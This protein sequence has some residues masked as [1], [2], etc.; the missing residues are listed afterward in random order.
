MA[1][2]TP[3]QSSKW[4]SWGFILGWKPHLA[5]RGIL[6][7]QYRGFIFIS[8]ACHHLKIGRKK[9]EKK[10]E[11]SH[12]TRSW[13]YSR[14]GRSSS[15]AWKWVGWLVPA[16]CTKSLPTLCDSMDCSPPGSSVHGILQ[17]STLEWVA[18]PF[19]R[20]SSWPRDWTWASYVSC[21]GRWVFFITR[22]TWVPALVSLICAW[23]LWL[24]LGRTYPE[25]LVS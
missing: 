17:A 23:S 8:H 20:G 5:H 21:I 3:L 7:G 14:S 1:V 13:G 16:L 6:L 18:I 4:E 2:V 24:S 19:S 25:H 9:K 22:S 11:D 12:M 15:T 10:R